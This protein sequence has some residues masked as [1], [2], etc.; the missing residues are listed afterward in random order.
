MVITTGN[1]LAAS[2]TNQKTIKKLLF[3]VCSSAETE[4][5]EVLVGWLVLIFF[6]YFYV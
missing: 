4:Q 6:C 2:P 1:N 3:W 5:Q